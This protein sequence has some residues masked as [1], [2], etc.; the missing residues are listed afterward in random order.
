MAQTEV[1]EM[2]AILKIMVA[3]LFMVFL[4]SVAIADELYPV[5]VYGYGPG[6]NTTIAGSVVNVDRATGQ[7]TVRPA[8][9][10]TIAGGVVSVSTDSLTKVKMCD[11]GKKL[12]DIKI[13]ETV[14][15][16]YHDGEEG[17]RVADDIR[18]ITKAC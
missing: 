6:A 12:E 7:L 10:N 8:N 4:A 16:K 1:A 18:I 13:G 15:V 14:K 2:K 3:V 9:L 5:R 11:S 17:R